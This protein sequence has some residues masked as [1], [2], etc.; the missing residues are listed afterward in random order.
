MWH[1]IRAALSPLGGASSVIWGNNH[2]L[3]PAIC[4]ASGRCHAEFW[5]LLRLVH[6]GGKGCLVIAI[7][8]RAGSLCN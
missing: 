8:G 5:V 7:V 3:V 2:G 1:I 4:L 6:V